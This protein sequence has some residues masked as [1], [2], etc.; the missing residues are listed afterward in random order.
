MEDAL[1]A[2]LLRADIDCKSF[3]EAQAAKPQRPGSGQLAHDAMGQ[4]RTSIDPLGDK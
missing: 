2:Y 4:L 3:A 1:A